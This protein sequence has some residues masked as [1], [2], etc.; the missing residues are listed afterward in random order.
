MLTLSSEAKAD[1]N[2]MLLIDENDVMAGHGASLGRIDEEPT[3]L[4]TK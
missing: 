1:A 3:I 4:L 2:P